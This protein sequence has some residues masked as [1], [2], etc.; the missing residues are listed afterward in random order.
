MSCEE[1]MAGLRKSVADGEIAER[2]PLPA[3]SKDPEIRTRT[4]ARTPTKGREGPAGPRP[5][6]AS[7]GALVLDV[8]LD[9]ARP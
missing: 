4:V 7:A 5:A 1:W 3:F 8:P 9:Q 6:M 2:R